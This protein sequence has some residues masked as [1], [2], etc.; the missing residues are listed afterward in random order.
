MFTLF[1]F[2]NLILLLNLNI[3]IRLTYINSDDTYFN[4][5][6]NLGRQVKNNYYNF[7]NK[8]TEVQK[9]KRPE[10]RCTIRND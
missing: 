1:Y 7:I 4:K 5:Y 6:V 3:L 10:C 2:Y 8:D 9:F